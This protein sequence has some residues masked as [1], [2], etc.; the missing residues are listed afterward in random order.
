MQPDAVY[1][2]WASPGTLQ[3]GYSKGESEQFGFNAS[4]SADIGNHAVQFGLIYEQRIDRGYGTAPTELWSKMRAITNFHIAQLD[5]SNPHG[6]YVDDVFQDTIYYDRIYD[7]GTQN[8]FDI[9]LR[10]ALGLPVDG[11]DWIDIDSYDINSYTINYYDKDG[12][13]A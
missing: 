2:L 10:K 8:V 5:K 1:G 7:K 6:V 9:N 13:T 11:T 4:A 3:L 12:C